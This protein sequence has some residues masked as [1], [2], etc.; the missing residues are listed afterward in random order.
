MNTKARKM[1]TTEIEVTVSKKDEYLPEAFPL[2][3]ILKGRSTKYTLKAG[4]ELRD[5]LD[6]AI[7]KVEKNRG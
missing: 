7:K 2:N 5:K 1:M 3:V 6:K 4:R